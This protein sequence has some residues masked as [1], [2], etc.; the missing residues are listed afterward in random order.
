MRIGWIGFIVWVWLI[1]TISAA[2]M[3]GTMFSATEQSTLSGFTSWTTI[4]L[5]LDAPYQIAGAAVS[6]LNSVWTAVSMNWTFLSGDYA[7]FKL[8]VFG[9][10]IATIVYGLWITFFG[11]LRREV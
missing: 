5:S 8:I 2:V 1:G 7:W 4:H 6:F 3:A 9:P 10:I 11:M